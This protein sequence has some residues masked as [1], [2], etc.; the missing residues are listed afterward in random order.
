[1]SSVTPSADY[2]EQAFESA[3]SQEVQSVNLERKLSQSRN[4]VALRL[5]SAGHGSLKEDKM[6]IMAKQV[7]ESDMESQM[8][9]FMI[10]DILS[11]KSSCENLYSDDDDISVYSNNEDSKKYSKIDGTQIHGQKKSSFQY[12]FSAYCAGAYNHL[13]GHDKEQVSRFILDF[14]CLK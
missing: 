8:D 2:I 11:S 4:T 6:S 13:Q 7:K 5:G 10:K 3:G 12:R 14:S 9:E 1:M